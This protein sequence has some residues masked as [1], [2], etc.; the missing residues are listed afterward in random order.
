MKTDKLLV[1]AVALAGGILVG[2]NW[3]KIKK[4]VVVN[5]TKIKEKSLPV[6]KKTIENVKS[7]LDHISC[8][9]CKTRLEPTAKFCYKCGEKT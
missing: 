6:Y 9:Q 1:G 3:D 4:F 5:V 7:K 2:K 8:A